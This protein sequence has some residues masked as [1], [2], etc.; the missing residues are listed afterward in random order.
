MYNNTANIFLVGPMGA[1]KSSIG[2]Q[3]ADKLQREFYDSDV[4]VEAKAGTNI[5][6]IF[7]VEGE[8][9]LRNRETEAI[10]TLTKLQNI[11]LATG[12]GSVLREANRSYLAARGI[13]VY[14]KASIE[15]QLHRTENNR[16]RRPLL[17]VDDIQSRLIELAAER[18]PLYEEIADIVIDTTAKSVTS[19]T[20]KILEHLQKR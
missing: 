14:L 19:V 6:W 8:E 1:G 2:R 20:N 18:N 9:G 12:G 15:Q 13:V 16:E 11:V 5:G 3:L 10:E 17:K 7:D 4:E